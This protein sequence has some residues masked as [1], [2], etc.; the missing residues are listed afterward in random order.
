MRTL[1]ATPDVAGVTVPLGSVDVPTLEAILSLSPLG[2]GS[3]GRGGDA[4][5]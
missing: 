4:L 3:P 5:L 1:P 2:G